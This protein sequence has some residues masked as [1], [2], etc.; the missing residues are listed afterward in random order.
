MRPSTRI[1]LISGWV[2]AAALAG[3][4]LWKHTA[5]TDGGG[6]C[7][8]DLRD[9][10]QIQDPEKRRQV[11]IREATEMLGTLREKFSDDPV[12]VANCALAMHVVRSTASDG[13][14]RPLALAAWLQDS[15]PP[16]AAALWVFAVNI[17]R[18]TDQVVIASIDKQGKTL[19]VICQFRGTLK[20]P[21]YVDALSLGCNF[22]ALEG[23]MQGATSNPEGWF[24]LRDDY[25]RLRKPLVLP[26]DVSLAVAVRDRVGKMSNYVP[27][28]DLRGQLRTAK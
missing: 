13:D 12:I 17:R 26:R 7:R 23:V 11:L 4:V 22:D 3:L 5:G 20:T 19:R 18:E 21:S 27:V 1:I 15:A 10:L 16:C 25:E 8:A 28:R 14:D 2:L 6:L 9:S 24:V